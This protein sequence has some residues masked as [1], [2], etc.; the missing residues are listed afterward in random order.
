MKKTL[1]LAS[2]LTVSN[3]YA[4]S[5]QVPLFSQH[6]QKGDFN[7]F[8]PGLIYELEL[9]PEISA[10]AGGYHNSY[11]K[12]TLIAGFEAQYKH[13][14]VQAGFATG[15][16]EVHGNKLQIIG[17]IFAELPITGNL[18]ARVTVIPDKNGAIG[19]SAVI[20]WD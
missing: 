8:N 2:L 15:Y 3:L 10:I 12:T 14:G 16:E 19:L 7:E 13:V 18:A 20:S 5:I 11:S 6:F 1:L 4:D 17:T 9:T